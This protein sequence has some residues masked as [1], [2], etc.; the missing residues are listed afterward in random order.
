MPNSSAEDEDWLSAQEDWYEVEG[1]DSEEPNPFPHLPWFPDVVRQ[2]RET[3]RTLEEAERAAQQ[4]L[5][6]HSWTSSGIFNS[7][8]IRNDEK[9]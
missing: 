6:R 7:V 1:E 5:H 3:L 2:S 8:I 9:I 4:A